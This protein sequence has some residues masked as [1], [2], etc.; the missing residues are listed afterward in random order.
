MSFTSQIRQSDR[1]AAVAPK[2][3]LNVGSKKNRIIFKNPMV[4]IKATSGKTTT[5]QILVRGLIV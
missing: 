5:V 3:A 2:T 4:K 1:R